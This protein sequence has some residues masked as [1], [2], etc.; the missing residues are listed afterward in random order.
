[1]PTDLPRLIPDQNQRVLVQETDFTMDAL[2]RDI[3]TT[4]D[5]ATENGSVAV[6]GVEIGSGISARTPRRKSIDTPT[7]AC[8]CKTDSWWN[9]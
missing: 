5:E 2:G 8:W 3:C 1:M 6:D 7:C 9:P 4:W